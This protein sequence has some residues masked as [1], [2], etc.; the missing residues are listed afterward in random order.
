M[1]YLPVHL[2]RPATLDQVTGPAI[3]LPE[4]GREDAFLVTGGERPYVCFIA[5]SYTG[6][7]FLK[8][9][10]G[11]WSGVAIEDVNFQVDASSAFKPAVIDQPLGALIRVGAELQMFV[12]TTDRHGFKEAARVTLL[13]DLPVSSDNV[14]VG[15]TRWRAV[16]G[17]GTSRVVVFSYEASKTANT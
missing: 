8:E 17:E 6:D 14:E 15:F 11:S 5:G 16:V 4:P 1:D 10:A 2:L 12:G 3:V 9:K 13:A 7:G